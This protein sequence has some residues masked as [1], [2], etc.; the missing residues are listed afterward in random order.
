MEDAEQPPLACLDASVFL[1]VLI[2]EATRAPTEEIAGAGRVLK[3]VEKGRLRGVAPSILLGEIRY[4]YLREDKAGFE[5]A[6]AA[7][8]AEVHLRTVAI[9][10]PLAIRAAEFRRRY[11]SK[12]NAFSYNDGLYLATGLRER[13]GFLITTDPH[14]LQVTDL[15]T[16]PRASIGK[17][18]RTPQAQAC[19]KPYASSAHPFQHRFG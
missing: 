19:T 14:L 2:P 4:V 3:A 15:Q 16:L 8:E 17:G 6:Y 13:V 11:Y 5:I 7:L 9:T 18:G 1:A 10:V 12:R